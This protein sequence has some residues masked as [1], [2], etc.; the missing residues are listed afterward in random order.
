MNDW[1][2]TYT[3]PQTSSTR[4]RGLGRQMHESVEDTKL[5]TNKQHTLSRDPPSTHRRL[6]CPSASC[7]CAAPLARPTVFTPSTPLAVGVLRV[8]RAYSLMQVSWPR[9]VCTRTKH[10]NRLPAPSRLSPTEL[11]SECPRSHSPMPAR[12]ATSKT[13]LTARARSLVAARPRRHKAASSRPAASTVLRARSRSTVLTP[14]TPM[15]VG[16][17]RLHQRH[18]LAR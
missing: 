9:P 17:L 14:S 6:H 1:V 4:S 2:H 11:S 5:S 13:S 8:R 16:V 7:A 3:K 10:P 18:A 12:T 15:A